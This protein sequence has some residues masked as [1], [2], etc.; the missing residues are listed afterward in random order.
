METSETTHRSNL[1][2][3]NTNIMHRS[4]KSRPFKKQNCSWSPRMGHCLTCSL[5]CT[6]AIFTIVSVQFGVQA[7]ECGD[8]AGCYP[9]IFDLLENIA[10][11][12]AR[13]YSVSGTCGLDPPA[14]VQFRSLLNSD[15]TSYVCDPGQNGP[16]NLVDAQAENVNTYWQSPLMVA[17]AGAAPTPQFVE[18]RF[19]DEFLFY[20]MFVTFHVP[21]VQDP[22]NSADARPQKMAIEKLDASGT[23]WTPLVYLA[24]DCAA[25]YPGVPVFDPRAAT[26]QYDTLYC[27][28]HEFA[29]EDPFLDVDNL[30]N[31]SPGFLFDV[32]FSLLRNNP[33]AIAHYTTRGIRLN[34]QQPASLVPDKSYVIISEV[35]ID[36]RCS[37]S[38]HASQ[39]GG[40]NGATCQC[41]HNTA[42]DQCSSCLAL[43]NNKQWQIGTTTTANACEQ[44]SCNGY[45]EAC[46]FD[47]TKDHG[48]CTACGSNTAGDFCDSCVEGFYINPAYAN[49]STVP[50]C[51]PCSCSPEGTLPSALTT[52]EVTTGQCTCKERVE[53]RDCSV[54]KDTFWAIA[55]SKPLGCDA[56]SCNP[57]GSEGSINLC[58]KIT[59]RCICKANV[60]GDT[61]GSCKTATFNFQASNPDGCTPCDCDPGASTSEACNLSNGQC[62]CRTFIGTRDCSV[63]NEN[64]YVPKMDLIVLEPEEYTSENVVLRSGHGTEG[65]TVSG[66]GLVNLTPANQIDISFTSPF[67]GPMT[68]VARYEIPS[69]ETIVVLQGNLILTSSTGYTCSGQSFPAGQSWTLLYSNVR[70]TLRGGVILG[71]VCLNQGSTYT[72]TLTNPSSAF[73]VDSVLLMPSTSGMQ[74]ALSGRLD[75]ESLER[76]VEQT[77]N[78]IRSNRV[79]CSS[80]EYSAVAAFLDGAQACSCPA[81]AAVS[82]SVCDGRTGDCPCLPG[83]LAPDCTQC[84]VD[85]YSFSAA[86]GCTDCACHPTGSAS[87]TCDDTG[88]CQCLPNVQGQKCDVC[89]SEHYGLSTGEG[90][91]P[92]QCDGNY[93][94]NNNCN[95]QGQCLCKVGVAGPLCKACLDG[96]YNLSPQG[97]TQCSCNPQGSTDRSCDVSSGICQ[98]LANVEG[99]NCG[100]C[101][102]GF[103]GLGPWHAGGCMPCFCW[104][105]GQECSSAPGYYSAI[106]ERSWP[107]QTEADKWQAVGEDGQSDVQVDMPETGTRPGYSLRVNEAS[108][109]SFDIFLLADSEFLGDQA[110]SYGRSLTIVVKKSPPSTSLTF[111]PSE[112]ATDQRY[113]VILENPF[114]SVGYRWNSSG[115]VENQETSLTIQMIES[116][117]E[118]VSC[119]STDNT[120]LPSYP[121]FMAVLAELRQLKIRVYTANMSDSALDLVYVSLDSSVDGAET[122]SHSGVLINNE[123]LC[124]CET[125]YTGSS[126]ERCGKDYTREESGN[127]YPGTNCVPCS[128]N[129]HGTTVCTTEQLQASSDPST[130][131]ASITACDPVSGVCNC[132]DNTAGDHCELCVIGYYGDATRGT[133]NDCLPC[134]C[135]GSIVGGDVNVFATSCSANEA[136]DPVCTNCT[137]GHGGNRCEF[138]LDGYFGTPENATNNGGNCSLCNCNDRADTCDTRTGQCINC[139]NNTAGNNC[140]ICAPGFFGNAMTETCQECTCSNYPGATGNCDHVTGECECLPNVGGETCDVCD[141][142]T[143]N[144][145][146][147]RG[148]EPCNC[149][150]DGSLSLVC[151]KTT[152]DCPCRD[153]VQGRTCAECEPGFWNVN[154]TTGCDPCGC[155][156][157]GTI[158]RQ[159]GS[160]DPTCDVTTGQC[161][162]ALPGIVGRTCDV[163]SPISKNTYTYITLFFIGTFPSC[164]LCG[165]CFDS[166]ADKIE[167]EGNS[168]AM[169]D[170]AIRDIWLHY[171]N[172]TE[173]QVSAALDVIEEKIT[174]AAKSIS[175]VEELANQL[176][177]IQERFSQAMVKEKAV[178]GDI[179]DLSQ[180][181]QTV[182]AI[183]TSMTALTEMVEI[184]VTVST[185]VSDLRQQLDD[186][187]REAEALSQRG[188]SS[189]ANIERLS[190]IVA[191]PQERERQLRQQANALLAISSRAN[192]N[193]ELAANLYRTTVNPGVEDKATELASATRS[194]AEARTMAEEVQSLI[195]SVQTDVSAIQ[196]ATEALG[197]GASTVKASLLKAVQDLQQFVS[198]TSAAQITARQVRQSALIFKNVS[199][200]AAETMI[201]S[202]SELLED[203][204]ALTQAQNDLVK[205]QTQANT[206]QST[207]LATQLELESVVRQI[208]Q[209]DVSPQAVEALNRRAEEDL[210]TAEQ[211][212][213]DTQKALA[214]ARELNQD[215]ILMAQDVY[216]SR[217]LRTQATGLRL[218]SDASQRHI[219]ETLQEARAHSDKAEADAAD[220]TAEAQTQTTTIQEVTSCL[221]Q[222]EVDVASAVTSAQQMKERADTASVAQRTLLSLMVSI[223]EEDSDKGVVTVLTSLTQANSTLTLMETNLS[224]L[225]A[226]VDIAGLVQTLETQ[227]NQLESL[228]AELD[229]LTS[230]VDVILVSLQE[231]DG[232]ASCDNG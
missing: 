137:D 216:E 208:N 131:A 45:A 12:P 199:E 117:W 21:N 160:I 116:N 212:V 24:T 50:Y 72:I 156:A 99:D 34:I 133:E 48:V 39:C 106:T 228:N 70:F 220:I 128:C 105:H 204:A 176:Q 57:A 94:V 211:A 189:W 56:C 153:L 162:C 110:S 207:R 127:N 178:S 1:P 96:Y 113:D 54:C 203:L 58:D 197:T 187:I 33:D 143:F 38:G 144:L 119:A 19:T 64:Y 118:K 115:V 109:G 91:I 198:N 16:D 206:V 80:V 177:N 30:V 190:F 81:G 230:E 135:P 73:L 52:C 219:N 205:A 158:R 165:E 83:A 62:P 67:S 126:C 15:L 53:G 41:S 170:S 26:D 141:D 213:D 191:S 20:E 154:P 9:P 90:C 25:S 68:M 120:T 2:G 145:T 11:F 107:A 102:T 139:R 108:R 47:E 3:C 121:E 146:A 168:I 161:N 37:C 7:Q 227:Q 181:Q 63:P 169:A 60:E 114:C 134:G 179:S 232:A 132:R 214:K 202:T 180:T 222:V 155:N 149:S 142:T 229:A 4:S 97:C 150:A 225:E 65:A 183:L 55:E 44:C 200:K 159:D 77:M 185:S 6:F 27:R 89:A 157:E 98:C 71:D 224:E 8:S 51:L 209:S 175:A 76:C 40:P 66:R 223:G 221:D 100:T 151:N 123:E 13:T 28:E 75:Q 31:Y 32:S 49:D 61:C 166:W 86:T 74:A 167:F 17:S 194:V 59:G 36:A 193:Y 82:S 182:Q 42:G 124:Q 84:E 218:A 215:L 87:D 201:N 231:A 78:E 93:S 111:Q 22:F 10:S 125:G 129:G 69:L 14:S 130:C 136:G 92:C 95:D 226:L 173:Q 184:S 43:Y 85:A 104:S 46:T 35:V 79:D 88:K 195:E 29:G 147:G 103:F 164:E 5:A 152:G 122:S 210:F 217:E 101:K 163:C 112:S 138:C 148:C 196:A 171:D 192:Q 188:N 140:E 23:N 186:L 174:E 172:Q 18:F